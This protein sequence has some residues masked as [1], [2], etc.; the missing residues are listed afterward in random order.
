M[1]SAGEVSSESRS[2]YSRR[3]QGASCAV[4]SDASSHVSIAAALMK[5]QSMLN[6]VGDF[7]YLAP[8]HLQ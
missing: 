7:N 5:F 4:Y 3:T 8:V 2:S 1:S 6:F